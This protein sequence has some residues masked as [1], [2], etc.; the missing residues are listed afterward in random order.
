MNPWDCYWISVRVL[1]PFFRRD[2]RE[3]VWMGYSFCLGLW[4]YV[5]HLEGSSEG[6]VTAVILKLTC[7]HSESELKVFALAKNMQPQPN[8]ATGLVLMP[9]ARPWPLKAAVSQ[10]TLELKVLICR[11]IVKFTFIL[12]SLITHVSSLICKIA[13]TFGT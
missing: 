8:F 5:I 11:Q 3:Y 12:P 13:L 1:Q 2:M 9:K 7:S 10:K 6:F 4:W